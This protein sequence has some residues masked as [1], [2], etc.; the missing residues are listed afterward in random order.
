M[1]NIPIK[2]A[3]AKK[4]FDEKDNYFYDVCKKALDLRYKMIIALL[5]FYFDPDGDKEYIEERTNYAR[6]LLNNVENIMK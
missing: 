4:R 1:F 2:L 6:T 3:R 5:D